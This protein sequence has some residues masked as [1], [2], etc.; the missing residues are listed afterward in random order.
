L[1][2][3]V[4]GL[5]DLGRHRSSLSEDPASK[6]KLKRRRLPFGRLKVVVSQEHSA[7]GSTETFV[8]LWL[9]VGLWTAL[10]V[11]LSGL[12]FSLL[13]RH[14]EEIG[15]FPQR[16]RGYDSAMLIQTSIMMGPER[17]AASSNYDAQPQDVSE[18]DAFAIM[19]H[20]Q[21]FSSG[22][23]PSDPR[24][25]DMKTSQVE[26]L[27]KEFAQKYGGTGRNGTSVV[28]G[29]LHRA[30]FHPAS[31]LSSKAS[32]D[33]ASTNATE[34][35]HHI[36]S[37]MAQ[38]LPFLFHVAAAKSAAPACESDSCTS[39]RILCLGG[40]A[41][42]GV[43]NYRGQM[44]S[45]VLNRLMARV[46][47]NATPEDLSKAPSLR[48]Y[49][50]S[51]PDEEV[52][53]LAWCFL[54]QFADDNLPTWIIWDYA[55]DDTA[56]ATEKLESFLR[57]VAKRW[58]AARKRSP[59][60]VFRSLNARGRSLLRYYESI[61][62]D[63]LILNITFAA[64]PML[65]SDAP[66]R[67]AG[68]ADW[69]TFSGQGTEAQQNLDLLSVQHHELIAWLL[70]MHMLA[71]MMYN[72]VQ[73]VLDFNM[74]LSSH[75]APSQASAKRLPRPKHL[76][77][78]RSWSL[79]VVGEHASGLKCFSSY[80]LRS[81][82]AIGN[83]LEASG[84]AVNDA[85]NYALLPAVSTERDV[86][87]NHLNYL[88]IG[89]AVTTPMEQLLL[90]QASFFSQGWVLDLDLHSKRA[91]QRTAPDFL[92]F[93]DWKAAYFG[94]ASSPPLVLSIPEG[95]QQLWLCE[96]SSTYSPLETGGEIGCSIFR[97]VTI[98]VNGVAVDH[99]EV[100]DSVSS[101]EKKPCIFVP[102]TAAPVNDATN[103]ATSGDFL[104][105]SLQV[106]SSQSANQ[107]SSPCSLAHVLYV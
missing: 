25:F 68:F 55:V 34:Q 94:T 64:E 60:L 86:A 14:V 84:G 17:E 49:H 63:V 21:A 69:S 65:R 106:T 16:T 8:R 29:L 72:S 35:R 37:K 96:S 31:L 71:G 11:L 103:R 42:A 59:M 83:K 20:V 67:P 95:T 51:M 82:H 15:T 100:V 39:I 57:T 30:F 41:A 81:Y 99:V 62:P 89:G 40:S 73:R 53:P 32:I 66:S 101:F 78:D 92:G 48:V 104:E 80:T 50:A 45:A 10:V 79:I 27:M 6:M 93:D 12:S 3:N 5:F 43:G 105:V 74:E 38:H 18:F 7:S 33:G 1:F 52:L 70:T 54:S 77:T 87:P 61:L 2:E 75:D 4:I 85:G 44:Y 26:S 19:S 56:A 98:R 102:L 24:V 13:R 28:R 90:P 97:D 107:R 47:E 23:G 88:V 22:K 36:V 46:V 76:P 9:T 58:M 91:K